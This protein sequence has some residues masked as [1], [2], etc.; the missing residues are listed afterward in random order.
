MSSQTSRVNS[1]MA[2]TIA[3]Y[4][5]AA[6]SG[7]VTV[8]EVADMLQEL[9]RRDPETYERLRRVLFKVIALANEY[10]DESSKTS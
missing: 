7:Q 3:N 8:E 1:R 9:G 10:S 2:R 4:K 5:A 6:A